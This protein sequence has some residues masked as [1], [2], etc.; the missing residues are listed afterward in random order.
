MGRQGL[1][2]TGQC[3]KPSTAICIVILC[4]SN[5]GFHSPEFLAQG[6][7]SLLNLQGKKLKISYEK[8]LPFV[9]LSQICIY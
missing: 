5:A 7:L 1:Q 3:V 6:I 9:L 4:I 2:S 8:Q